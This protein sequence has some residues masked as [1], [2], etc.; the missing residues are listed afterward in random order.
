MMAAFEKEGERLSVSARNAE[1][2]TS[3]PMRRCFRKLLRFGFVVVAVV[4][5]AVA[6]SLLSSLF[7]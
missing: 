5:A 7:S 6:S 3:F 2:I 4:A 1:P